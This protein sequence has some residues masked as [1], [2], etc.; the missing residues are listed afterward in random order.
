MAHAMLAVLANGGLISAGNL[1][2]EQRIPFQF[3]VLA[4]ILSRE[5]AARYVGVSVDAFDVE[6]A[7]GLWPGPR[8]RG[9]KGGRLT[10]DRALLDAPAGGGGGNL[11]PIDSRALRGVE[12][13]TPSQGGLIRRFVAVPAPPL[14]EIDRGRRDH[15]AGVCKGRNRIQRA[16]M[17]LIGPPDC[18]RNRH[19]AGRTSAL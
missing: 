15:R 3:A 8:R 7:A 9:G 6:V 14:R 18:T 5:E 10:W 1:R 12:P 17:R 2:G 11:I 16:V 13:L 19:D 4:K